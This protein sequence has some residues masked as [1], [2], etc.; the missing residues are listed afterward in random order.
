MTWGYGNGTVTVGVLPRV[1]CMHRLLGGSVSLV[2]RVRFHVPPSCHDGASAYRYVA[3]P[4]PPEH[5]LHVI[6]S[7][8]APIGV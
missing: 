8:Y 7:A 3:G 4:K 1:T 5:R 6:D 2:L